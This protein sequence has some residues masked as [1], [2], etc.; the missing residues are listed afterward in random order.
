MRPFSFVPGR[1]IL[2]AENAENA[3]IAVIFSP[4]FHGGL[5]ILGCGMQGKIISTTG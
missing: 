2:T 5:P 3:E 1:E 4:P